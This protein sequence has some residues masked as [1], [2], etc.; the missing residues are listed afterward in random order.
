MNTKQHISKMGY[1]DDSPYRGRE[2]ININTPSG[3]ID[4]SQTGIPIF[5]NGVLLPPYSGQHNMGTTNVTEIPAV[6]RGGQ[7]PMA[8]NGLSDFFSWDNIK[9]AGELV[10][11][12]IGTI[13]DTAKN[14]IADNVDPYGYGDEY[15][16]LYNAIFTTQDQEYDYD[17]EIGED[18]SGERRDLLHL[19]MGLEQEG[20]TIPQQNQYV[21]TK[22]HNKGDIYYSSPVTEREIQEEIKKIGL[23]QKEIFYSQL[24]NQDEKEADEEWERNL[25]DDFEW[26]DYYRLLEQIDPD[27]YNAKYDGKEITFWIDEDDPDKDNYIH[28]KDVPEYKNFVESDDYGA[29]EKKTKAKIEKDYQEI[30]YPDFETFLTTPG[31]EEEGTSQSGGFY[32]GVLG[33]FTLNQGEDEK[34]KYISYY[35]KWDLSPFKG[36]GDWK[37]KLSNFGQEYILGVDPTSIYNRMYYTQDKDGNYIFKGGGELP[38]AQYS[39]TDNPI[40]NLVTGKGE[41]WI[42]NNAIKTAGTYVGSNAFGRGVSA[43][44]SNPYLLPIAA[45]VEGINFMGTE[46]GGNIV[47]E[48]KTIDNIID[49]NDGSQSLKTWGIGPKYRQ[50]GFLPKAHEGGPDVHGKNTPTPYQVHTHDESGDMQKISSDT[51]IPP[52]SISLVGDNTLT[53]AHWSQNQVIDNEP[54]GFV[55]NGQWYPAGTQVLSQ[56]YEKEDPGFFDVV[57]NVIANPYEAFAR[58]MA[59]NGRDAWDGTLGEGYSLDLYNN[60]PSPDGFNFANEMINPAKWVENIN[61]S[62][63]QGDYKGAGIEAAF[64]IPFLK[65]FKFAK[66]A[67]KATRGSKVFNGNSIVKA[68]DNVV[69]VPKW[70][71]GVTHYG[72]VGPE[73]WGGALTG[74]KNQGRHLD[75]IGFDAST[76]N[77]KNIVNHGNMHGRQIVE[78]ALPDGKTQLFYKSTDLAGKGTEG[79]WQP[80]G[81]H[82]NT[83]INGNQTQNWFIKDAGFADWYG[84]KSFRDISGNLDRIAAEEGWDMSKQILKSKLKYGGSIPIA[85]DGFDFNKSNTYGQGPNFFEK[86]PMTWTNQEIMDVALDA[87]AV[88]HPGFDFAHAFTKFREGEY[89]DAALYA[90][91]GILPFSAGPLVSGTKN[92]FNYLKNI[93]PFGKNA[94]IAKELSKNLNVAPLGNTVNK[95]DE[96][97]IPF[98]NTSKDDGINIGKQIQK[99]FSHKEFVKQSDILKSDV[100]L[101]R[102]VDSEGLIIKDG[103]LFDSKQP[104]KY[105]DDYT[106]NRNTSHWGYGLIESTGG[107]SIAGRSTAII[108]D[109]KSLKGSGKAMDLHPTDTYFYSKGNFEIPN[110]SLI[111]TKDKKLYN[112][113]KKETNIKNIK[114]IENV[115]DKEFAAIIN[116]YGKTEGENGVRVFEDYIKK[117]FDQGLDVA[118][119]KQVD[120][121]NSLSLAEQEQRVMNFGFGE[122]LSPG[123]YSTAESSARH[124]FDPLSVLEESQQLGVSMMHGDHIKRLAAMDTRIQINELDKLLRI[125]PDKSTARSLQKE[126]AELNGFKSYK[127]FK[128]SVDMTDFKKYGGEL[129]IAQDGEETDINFS[130]LE[131]GIKWSESLNG[132]LM[133]N[134]ETSASGYYGDLFDNLDYDGTRDEF[135][136]DTDYQEEYFRKRAHGEIENIPGLIN[137]GTELLEEYKDV[138]HGLSGLEISALSNMLGRQGTREYLGNVI[139]DGSTLAEVFPH[140]YGEDVAQTNKTPQEYIDKFNEGLLKKKMGGSV[141]TKVKRLNQQLELYNKGGKISP[142]AKRQ[143]ESLNMIKPKMQEGGQTPIEHHSY[144]VKG[145]DNLTRIARDNNMSLSDLLMLNP[146][147]INNP[148]KIYSGDRIAITNNATP[149]NDKATL[150]YKIKKGDTLSH[151]ASKYGVR[152]EDIARINNIKDPRSIQPNQKIILPDNA[153]TNDPIV[154]KNI[155]R[156]ESVYV[157]SV[158]EAEVDTNPNVNVPWAKRIPPDISESGQWETIGKRNIKTEINKMDQ[159][160]RIIEGMSEISPKSTKSGSYTVKSGDNLGKIALDNN[161]TITELEKL[162]NIDR[163]KDIQVGQNIKVNTPTGKPYIIVDEKIGRMHLYYPGS[164]KPAKSY[165][166]LTGE[167]EGDAQ[168]V[169]KIGV[170]KDG[171]TLNREELNKAMKDNLPEG[172]KW[173]VD[174]L[175]EFGEG[176]TTDTDW[177]AGN[178]QSGA[179]IYTIGMI[180]EDSGYYDDSGNNNPTPSFVLNNSNGDEV[181]MVI[182]TVPSWKNKDRV[183]NL[184]DNDG[185]NN[186]MT[187]G[188]INGR[189][190]DLTELYNTPG[191][192]EGTMIYVLPEDA[193]NNFV[194][195]N[196][197]INFYASSDNQTDAQTYIDEYGNEQSGHGIANKTTSNYKPINITF[198]KNYYQ[199]NSERYDGTAEGEEKEFV[200]NTQPFLNSL[201]DSKKEMMDD[202]GMD[203]DTYNDLAMIAF[204]IYGYES[205]MGD[206]GSGA[207][208]LVK[209]GRKKMTQLG[210]EKWYIPEWNY[211]NT[212]PDVRSK[213]DTYGVD[214]KWNSIG[215]TQSKWGYIE[216]DENAMKIMNKLGINEDNYAEWMMDPEKSAKFTIARLYDFHQKSQASIKLRNKHRRDG[217]FVEGDDFGFD[218][219]EKYGAEEEVYDPFTHLPKQWSPT[220]PDYTNLVNKYTDY[221]TLSETDIDDVDN[222]LI[223]KGE[224]TDDNV[225]SNERHND[226]DWKGKIENILNLPEAIEQSYNSSTY[227]KPIVDTLDLAV[228]NASNAV[229]EWWDEVDLNP[230]WKRGGEFSVGN[231][232]QF[233][234]DYIDGKYKGTKQENKS[235]KMYDKLNRMYYNDS[236]KSN[237]HQLD[238]MNSILRSN[239]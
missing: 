160:D 210:K 56:G 103:K 226:K 232:V 235:K 138:D 76:L 7:L 17:Y 119:W 95:V 10:I 44:L 85:Q 97:I 6:Q 178:K 173:T 79:L 122:R 82:A 208:N 45:G 158:V 171:K 131:K 218:P 196:G 8:Q 134:S 43:T 67:T 94:K 72:K 224:Y 50:G 16:R 37:E 61:N 20:N 169:T 239:R 25:Q 39:I 32:G 55:V 228:D 199:T 206:E 124:S 221:I 145:G 172:T 70:S 238:I 90:G 73:A 201:A 215:W 21:P 185:S 212:S 154:Q 22:G 33:N 217:T 219:V 1:R 58:G 5:A 118:H 2:S 111:L 100:P 13:I 225:A 102:A 231:Q 31:N 186:R 151:I 59:Y 126:L 198:D 190:E 166:I 187:N 139:R 46:L 40:T 57:G 9:K 35:D 47:N 203:G 120:N 143:L 192:G 234:S 4:M 62:L 156:A 137:N 177:D 167:N 144:V 96:K 36:D 227:I 129:P 81:G 78:V 133:K 132:T 128:G 91:F 233:Y 117:N 52:A 26:E 28:Y 155:K 89:T 64:S 149:D 209:A 14:K 63:D 130:D 115:S 105:T 168:T 15:D 191:V 176:Y 152:Y 123:S 162:N 75:E 153:N 146:K 164:D 188:C 194:F 110:N 170:I 211:G 71:Q 229:S 142:L 216:E 163:K 148:S 136:A 230:F 189:C 66:G 165:P 204:G 214:G 182:H 140:L 11:D 213:H 222:N 30:E 183:T 38:K 60:I 24:T 93:N 157:P 74:M 53:S 92:A 29:W 65:P 23:N 223:V 125:S 121:Y 114:L 106:L 175:L 193:G 34:G 83:M 68:T 80:F 197:V 19:L 98:E 147:Y 48:Q 107:S 12:P 141:M 200:N 195:E 135:I 77:G 86:E 236:K 113:I 101:T 207:E 99:S 184:N 41:K 220:S 174:N 3:I 42:A 27:N 179:G 116:R 18:Q 104:H 49:D 159:A 202:L 88:F 84:S 127:E 87:G 205:G 237:R 109:F 54:E 180:N 69:T 150:T 51:F 108:S 112:Q 181:P 161:M